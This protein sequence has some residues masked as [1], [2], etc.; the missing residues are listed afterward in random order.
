MSSRNVLQVTNLSI[1]PNLFP[2]DICSSFATLVSNLISL[3]SQKILIA[4]F[5]NSLSPSNT[6]INPTSSLNSR[7]VLLILLLFSSSYFL[8][9]HILRP[10]GLIYLQI[11]I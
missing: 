6:L 2:L 4:A 5:E 7:I 10:Y 11:V 8:L 9:K 1:I 3:S